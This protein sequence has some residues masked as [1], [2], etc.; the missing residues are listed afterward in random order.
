MDIICIQETKINPSK[1]KTIPGYASQY[2]H[3][4]VNRSKNIAGG[5]AIFIKNNINYEIITVDNPL[6]SSGEVAFEWQLIK[7]YTDN[8]PIFLVNLY[9]RGVDQLSLSKITAP[10][11]QDNNLQECVIT[12]DFNAHHEHWGSSSTDRTGRDIWQWVENSGLV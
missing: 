3:F 5:L 11:T 12:G 10:I 2:K 6:N 7:V 9:G 1:L 4:S 8:T